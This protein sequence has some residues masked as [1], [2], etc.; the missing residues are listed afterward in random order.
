ML[1]S[2][3]APLTDGYNHIYFQIVSKSSSD[4]FRY[5]VYN[6]ISLVLMKT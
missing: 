3:N 2:R 1:E 4:H 5:L 6:R